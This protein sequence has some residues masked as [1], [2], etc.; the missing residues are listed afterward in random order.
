MGFNIASY[1]NEIEKL[2]RH[3]SVTRLEVFGSAVGSNFNEEKSD[4]DFLVEFGPS[5]SF[6]AF[7]QYF[8]LK[9]ALTALFERSIDLVERKAIKNPFFQ[10]KIEKEKQSIYHAQ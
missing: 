3:Y 1:T 2:C 8:G 6:G 7:D 4:L 5:Q 10:Q 9:E